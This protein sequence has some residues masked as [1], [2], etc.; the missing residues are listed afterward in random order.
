MGVGEWE[1]NG[2]KALAQ[3]NRD[4]WIKIIERT[5]Q[6]LRD[7]VDVQQSVLLSGKRGGKVLKL[8]K[9]TLS[10]SGS[11]PSFKIAR[12]NECNFVV[13]IQG[14]GKLQRLGQL[15]EEEYLLSQVCVLYFFL[16]RPRVLE[17]SVG[18][19][20]EIDLFPLRSG[21]ASSASSP[22]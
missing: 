12:K 16:S 3:G 4:H 11:L 6:D 19:N 13:S 2:G 17:H 9:K 10:L 8:F 14:K 18:L 20:C 15:L 1:M 21:R 22:C 7:R 5:T